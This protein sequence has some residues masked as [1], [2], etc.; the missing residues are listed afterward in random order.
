MGK[1]H[2]I[3]VFRNI[4]FLFSHSRINRYL[5]LQ[6]QHSVS[7]F[8]IQEQ[9]GHTVGN[10]ILLFIS[11]RTPITIQSIICPKRVSDKVTIIDYKS[12]TIGFQVKAGGSTAVSS[13]SLNNYT[14]FFHI[15]FFQLCYFYY[16]FLSFI[17]QAKSFLKTKKEGAAL[18]SSPSPYFSF[19][20][21]FLLPRIFSSVIVS[22]VT[23]YRSFCSFNYR[24][25]SVIQIDC[26]SA[27]VTFQRHVF[28][29]S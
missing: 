17:F 10:H 29:D 3:S 16:N 15:I 12:A 18:S 21:S 25:F 7:T 5:L 22:D 11:V 28:T 23:S 2:G 19:I 13:V 14:V 4:L 9:I 24:A 1:S 26:T 6:E 8:F 20:P 27:P